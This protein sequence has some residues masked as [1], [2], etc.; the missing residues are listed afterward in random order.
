MAAKIQLTIDSGIAHLVFA[1]PDKRNAIDFD[2]GQQYRDACVAAVSSDEVRA[3]LITA[4]GPAF[5]VGGD[6][7]AMARSGVSGAPGSEEQVTG[8]QV[9]AAAQIIHEGIASLVGSSKPIVAAVRGAV[10]GGGIGLMLAADYVVAGADLRVSGSYADVGLT[11][12]LGV[13]TLLTRAVGERRALEMLVG[14]REL[15]SST[16]HAWGMVAEVTDDPD[17]RATALA[18]QWAEG[19]SR[20]LGEAKRLVRTS[21]NRDFAASLDDEARSIGAAFDGDDSRARIAA[22]AAASAARGAKQ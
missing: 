15:D 11:P 14:R 8:A 20:A 10:A 12:D 9:T 21:G 19:P 3:I 18:R 17:S 1:N 4:L 6:L 5:C 7:L 2:A 22:F 13:S 16:A